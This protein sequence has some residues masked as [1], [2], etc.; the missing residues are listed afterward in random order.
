MTSTKLGKI[1]SYDPPR[2]R[3]VVEWDGVQ[4]SFSGTSFYSG[5]PTRYAVSGD[6]VEV[7][8]SDSLQLLF[9]RLR[10]G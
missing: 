3:G 5:R 6:P 9:I 2:A 4:T 8:L 1:V 10:E 7:V